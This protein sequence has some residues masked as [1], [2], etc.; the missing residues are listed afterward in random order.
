MASNQPFYCGVQCVVFRRGSRI[1]Q[2]CEVLLGRR[3]RAAGEGQWAL[4]GGHVELNETPLMTARRELQEETG[5]T[6]EYAR[7]GA[8]FFTYTTDLPYAHAPVVFDT[9]I[10]EPRLI[11]GERF[12]ELDF[13]RLDRLPRPLFE[14]SQLTLGGLDDSPIHAYFGGDFGPSFLKVDMASLDPSEN[15]NRSYAVLF[16][17]DGTNATL[18]LMWGRRDDRT[19]RTHRT[20]YNDLDEGLRKL[21]ETIRK[22][23]RHNYYVTGVSGD[24]TVDRLHAMLPDVGSMKVVS[25]SLIRRLLRDDE[26]RQAYARDFYLY[27]PGVTHVPNEP[28]GQDPLF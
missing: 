17:W 6:G 19:R 9:V 24:V 8:T 1:A 26:F 20:M 23:M 11:A 7:L 4:P 13:F 21:E 25:E 2:P 15:R 18:I 27:R 14:P 16:L 28:V 5:L 10:G 3:F 12:S 22:R